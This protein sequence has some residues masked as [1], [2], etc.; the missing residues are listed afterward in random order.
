MYRTCRCQLQLP[1]MSQVFRCLFQFLQSLP[2]FLQEV[3]NGLQDKAAALKT[4]W[5]VAATTSR[6]GAFRLRYTIEREK[7]ALEGIGGGPV[8]GSNRYG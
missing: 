6:V 2:A 4:E 3:T 1:G 5:Q 7:N 8:S